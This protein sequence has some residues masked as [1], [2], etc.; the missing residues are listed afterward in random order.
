MTVDKEYSNEAFFYIQIYFFKKRFPH[1]APAMNS[2][3]HIN[4]DLAKI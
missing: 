3:S 1:L 4:G 2:S